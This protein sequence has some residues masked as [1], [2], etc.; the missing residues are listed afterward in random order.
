MSIPYYTKGDDTP[1]LLQ[2]TTDGSTAFNLTGA[3]LET[4]FRKSDGSELVIA[5]GS[6]SITSAANGQY[7]VNWTAANTLTL[8]AE[9]RAVFKTKIT[10]A[11]IVTTIW[12]DGVLEIREKKVNQQRAL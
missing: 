2:A 6:H 8:K 4:T 10:Q 5:N 3:T 9:E 1:L 7:Q 11:S 12:F